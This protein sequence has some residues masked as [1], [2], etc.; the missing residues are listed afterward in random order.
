MAGV[1]ARVPVAAAADVFREIGRW[2][3]ET[4]CPGEG[5]RQPVEV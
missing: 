3:G 1:E 2:K 4:V 5:S